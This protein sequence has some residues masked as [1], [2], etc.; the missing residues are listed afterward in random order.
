MLTPYEVIVRTA[1]PAIRSMLA[2]E[3]TKKYKLKQRET[4]ELMHMT[5]AAVSYYLAR[6]RGKYIVYLENTEISG[7][8]NELCDKLYYNRLSPKELVLEINRIIIFMMKNR[9]LCNYHVILEPEID[10]EE[11]NLCDEILKCLNT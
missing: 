6:S 8:I 10:E 11:C 2:Q 1:L 9:Y 4:A 5:Q 3:L 7:M